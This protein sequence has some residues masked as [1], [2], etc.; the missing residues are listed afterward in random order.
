M[1]PLLKPAVNTYFRG[2]TKIF[3][4]PCVRIADYLHPAQD[5]DVQPPH[6]EPPLDDSDG[7]EP[8]DLP[9]PK[10][11]ISLFVFFEPH[12]SQTASRFAPK[13]IFSKSTLQAL[14]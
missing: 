3:V 7:E 2:S 13:T 8:A 12:F 1:L 6:P 11:D 5:D 4:I 14:Q 10:R 9:M